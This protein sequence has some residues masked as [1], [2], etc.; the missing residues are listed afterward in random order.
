MPV[1]VSV[2]CRCLRNL[3]G[4][5]REVKGIT[6]SSNGELAYSCAADCTVKVWKI[7]LAPAE[8]G[9][10]EQDARPVA[11]MVGQKAFLGVDCQY[12]GDKFATCGSAV[13]IWDAEHSE[14]ID[15]FT[16]GCESTYAVRFNPVRAPYAT[17]R[18]H[19]AASRAAPVLP[20][21]RVCM[22]CRPRRE[23][24]LRAR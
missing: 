2:A 8:H 19:R 23:L 9:V 15:T 6:V 16:W 10:V 11:D 18:C 4:H 12:S 14:P 1:T 24:R 7:P 3:T 20:C 22:R 17:P 5:T 13:D 21:P